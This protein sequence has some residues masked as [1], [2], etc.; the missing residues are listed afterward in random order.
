MKGGQ[1]VLAI[2]DT[3]IGDGSDNNNP[4][5][6]YFIFLFQVLIENTNIKS[7]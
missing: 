5:L 7:D 4:G 1:N 3:R 2:F 6:K